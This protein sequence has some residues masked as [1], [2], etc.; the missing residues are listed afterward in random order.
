M[1]GTTTAT[2]ATPSPTPAAPPE[3][4]SLGSI[5]ADWWTRVKSGDVGSLPALLGLLFLVVVFSI[6]RPETFTSELNF[7][8]LI[9]QSAGIMVLAMGLVFVLLLGEI[10]LAAGYTGGFAAAML[11]LVLTRH[12]W[13][14]APSIL[15]AL[16]AGT[17]VGLV[18][19][20]LVAKIGIPSFVVTLAF[21]LGLQGV[22]LKIIGEGGTIGYRDDVVLKINNGAMPLWAGWALAGVVIA[23][24]AA[25]TL[26]QMRRRKAR[27]LATQPTILWV[28]KVGGLA[29]AVLGAVYYLSLERSIRPQ[30]ISLK[31]V[32]NVVLILVVLVAVLTYLLTRTSWGRH[33]YAVGGNAEAARRAGIN[34]AW[35]K[36]SCFMMCS[37]MAAA[38]GLIIASR[39]NSVSGLTGGGSTLLFAVAAAV[40]G[41][42]SLFGGKGRVTDAVIG[43]LV[44]AVINNGMGL[45][46][47][48]AS[49]V[50][51]V[52][53]GVL[54]LAAAVDAVT[55]RRAAASGRV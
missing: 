16:L 19:G 52:T 32:P 12:D 8:N 39:D 45:L 42:T 30:F 27:G 48:P 13:H 21:F 41:G 51:M 23:G 22:V 25:S 49:V 55:R 46:N 26:L 4:T 40:I 17:V 15:V 37:T 5:V 9:N 38:G 7:A 3:Q 33:V 11:G 43:G 50:F 2:S 24:Y 31:G 14:W 18:M 36:I 20:S 44:I 35:V 54:L 47:Q 1:S 34:V 53:G 10:D 6:L 29:I 28:L